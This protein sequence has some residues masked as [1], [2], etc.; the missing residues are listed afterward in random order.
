MNSTFDNKVVVVTGG[1]KGIGFRCAQMLANKGAKVAVVDRQSGDL[2]A[3]AV[4]EIKKDGFALGYQ[5]DVTDIAQITPTIERIRKEIGEIDIFVGCA[6]VNLTKPSKAESIIEEDW[7][8]VYSVNIKGLFY[9]IQ[10]VASQSMIP[11]KKGVIVNIS[12]QAGMVGVPLCISYNTSKAAVIQ[13]TRSLA[14]EWAPL[15]IRVNSVAPTWVRTDLSEPLLTIP[16]FQEHELANIPL[17]RFATVDEVAS[18]VCFLASDQS[19]MTTGHTF[20]VDG[21]WTSQ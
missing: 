9:C 13:L 2:L 7:D 16:G 17:N 12:S 15:N 18:A 20:P 10:A 3:E 8:F 1:V 5:L 4:G 11:R 14:I 21:G 6:G 19:G